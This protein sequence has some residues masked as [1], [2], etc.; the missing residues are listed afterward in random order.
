MRAT[1]HRWRKH[2]TTSN[3]S[4]VDGHAQL[5]TAPPSGRTCCSEHADP[6]LW[7]ARPAA[8]LLGSHYKSG[9][10]S[11]SWSQSLCMVGLLFLGYFC[12]MWTSPIVSL[13]WGEITLAWSRHSHIC[14]AVVALLPS[15]PVFPVTIG[16]RLASQTGKTTLTYALT[17]PCILCRHFPQ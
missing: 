3:V 12:P 16:V 13:C 14:T 15:V 5:S 11:A 6:E 17:Y 4:A 10:L 1:K 7:P 9:L 8:S 2:I